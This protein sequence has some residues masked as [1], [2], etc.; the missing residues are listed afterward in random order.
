[1]SVPGIIHDIENII[2]LALSINN[3]SC[4]EIVM[5]INGSKNWEANDCSKLSAKLFDV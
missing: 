5:S 1:M 2:V 3:V 4:G